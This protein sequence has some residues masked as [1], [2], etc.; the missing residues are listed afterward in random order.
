LD[1][2][3][4][5]LPVA[6]ESLSKEALRGL[7]EEFVSRD[8]TDYGDHEQSLEDKVSAVVVQLEKGEVRIVF[9][10]EMESANIVV[11]ESWL[12]GESEE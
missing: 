10:R 1:P 4:R 6:S 7:I 2:D 11:A 8:G 12:E 9:D 5:Y 3:E